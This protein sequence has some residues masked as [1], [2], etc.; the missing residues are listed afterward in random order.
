MPAVALCSRDHGA[1]DTS[2]PAEQGVAPEGIEAFLDAVERDGRIEPH[3]LIIH[4]HG[5]RI[6]EGYWAPHT[7]ER[8]RLVYSVSKTFTGTALGLQLGEGRLSL[9][10]LVSEHLP[11]RFADADA[12]TRRMRIRHIASMST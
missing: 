8:N 6:A 4:R 9:D 11:T 7:A 10:D 3:G 5:R 2:S 12:A 1:M